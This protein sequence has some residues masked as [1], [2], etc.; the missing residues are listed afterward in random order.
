MVEEEKSAGRY[1]V[2]SGKLLSLYH[3]SAGEYEEALAVLRELRQGVPDDVELIE[4]TGVLLRLLG[5]QEQAIEAL[6]E[7]HEKGPERFNVCDALAHSFASTQNR[8]EM[9]RF[10]KLSL[11]LKDRRVNSL[12]VLRDL[13]GTTPEPFQQDSG[14]KHVISFSLWGNGAR[15][16]RGAIRNVQAAFD[17]YPGWICRFYCD[18]SVPAHFREHLLRH[19]A[20]IVMKPRPET[21]FDGLLWRFEVIEDE[22]VDRYLVRDCDSVVNVQERIAV[23]EWLASDRWFHVMRDFPSHTEVI[24]A[25]MWGGASGGLPPV[26]ELRESFRP[27]TAPTRTFDQVFLR[28]CVWPIVRQ[29]VLI[30]DSVYTGSLGSR[31]FPLPGRLP[32]PFHVGQNE[33]AVRKDVVVDL[34]GSRPGDRTPLVFL[35]GSDEESV[36]WVSRVLGE[37]G[38]FS[39]LN[40][41]SLAAAMA[42]ATKTFENLI[43][44][45]NSGVDSGDKGRTVSEEQIIPVV[46]SLLEAACLALGGGGKTVLILDD[47]GDLGLLATLAGSLRARILNVIRDP[48]DTASRRRLCDRDVAREWASEWSEGIGRI[49]SASRARPGEVE[50]V[51]YEDFAP[52]RA[53]GTCRSL[54]VFLRQEFPGGKAPQEKR[55][56]V[57]KPLPA[58]ISEVIE[59]GAG[60]WMKKLRYLQR[61]PVT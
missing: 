54:S 17:L 48:R 47:T 57:G 30:H 37:W 9:L 41:G 19:G 14:K 36:E 61:I 44:G 22:S 42:E 60:E 31:D 21:F 23:D 58:E 49:A 2:D 52:A 11:E 8:M 32:K 34:P 40:R 45:S 15:Y 29:S 26:R 59:A 10:G 46:E 6:L 51:R 18:D 43:G 7:A 1:S 4:N 16:L 12:P 28:E 33:A 25:G 3:F 50:L 39:I 24:L 55:V 53:A 13:S 35:T 38:D 20:E 56:D 5:R 27:N